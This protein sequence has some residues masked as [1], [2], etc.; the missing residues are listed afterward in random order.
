M[1]HP[2]ILIVEHDGKL[3]ALLRA[4]AEQA[5]YS[6]REPKQL[7]TCLKLIERA[8]PSVLVLRIGRDL[9]REFVL[10]DRVSKTGTS[11]VVVTDSDHPRLIGIARDLDAAFVLPASRV[12]EQ[13]V[14]L[15]LSL[16]REEP[17]R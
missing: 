15:V 1:R 6:L 5:G 13:L 7:A 8:K 3:A 12:R 10:L 2:Q 14:E 9:E 11:V 4:A 17:V 16:M